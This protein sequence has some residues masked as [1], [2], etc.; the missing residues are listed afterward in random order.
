MKVDYRGVCTNAD[1]VSSFFLIRFGLSIR[2]IRAV[3]KKKFVFK[4]DLEISA[5]LSVK[6]LKVNFSA[7]CLF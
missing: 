6:N 7:L 2:Y 5:E 1:V 3:W 4:M